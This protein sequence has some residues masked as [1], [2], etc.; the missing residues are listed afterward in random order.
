MIGVC[1]FLVPFAAYPPGRLP[2]SLLLL[3]ALAAAAHLIVGTATGNAKAIRAGAG[4]A[5]L[6]WSAQIAMIGYSI[7]IEQPIFFSVWTSASGLF[8][9]VLP[10]FMAGWLYWVAGVEM[11]P[12]HEPA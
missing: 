7:A 9:D 4:L 3:L 8:I 6:T 1:I 10:L 5:T 2:Y 12:G 11:R